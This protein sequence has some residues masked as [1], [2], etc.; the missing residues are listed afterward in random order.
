MKWTYVIHDDETKDLMPSTRLYETQS[1][2][3]K[4]AAGEIMGDD[5][6]EWD[7][8]EPHQALVDLYPLYCLVHCVE[9]ADEAYER[10]TR[11][12]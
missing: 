6:M 3:M 10:Q 1:E 7:S 2:A 12:G 11:K 5:D 8:V 4:E 9:T